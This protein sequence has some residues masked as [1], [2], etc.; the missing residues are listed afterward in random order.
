M[1]SFLHAVS[2]TLALVLAGATA[3]ASTPQPLDKLLSTQD[4]PAALQ[5]Q[6]RGQRSIVIPGIA[7]APWGLQLCST[8]PGGKQVSIPGPASA[9]DLLLP[10]STDN[11]LVLS[12]R[13]YRFG[14]REQ[15]Q[16][17]WAQLKT[18][19]PRCSGSVAGADGL[20]SR[21]SNGGSNPIWIKTQML[22]GPKSSDAA[23]RYALFSRH[24]AVILVT[25]LSRLGQSMISASEQLAVQHVAARLG[26][27]L[28]AQP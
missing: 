4:L 11:S 7:T 17:A 21:L 18:A 13:L 12:A 5:R 3:L 14:S 24:G 10:L 23:A 27:K 2:A 15:A 16:T 22:D 26:Q 8:G 19:A 25:G 20:R 1:L 6:A 28:E 9:D